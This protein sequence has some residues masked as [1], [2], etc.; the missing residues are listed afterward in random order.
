[1][2]NLQQ[3]EPS[4]LLS[5]NTHLLCGDTA[6]DIA[7]GTGRN[8]VFLASRGYDVTGVEL[9]L[10]AVSAAMQV[11][12]EMG[13]SINAVKSDISDFDIKENYFDVIINFNFLDRD[14]M[15]IIKK[16]LKQGGLLFFETYTKDQAQFGRPSNPDFLL[17]RNELIMNFLDFFIIFYHERTDKEKAV[18]SLIAKKM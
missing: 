16:G 11:A 8:A 10:P 13:G 12:S 9:S 18:A 17:D 3:R 6:L 4:R 1:M 2:K 7:M 5:R 15:T 14:L